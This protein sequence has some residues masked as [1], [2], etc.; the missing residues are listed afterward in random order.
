VVSTSN[1]DFIN[2]VN[3]VKVYYV[4]IPNLYWMK[5]AKEQS[6]WKKPLW[7]LLDVYN[8]FLDR[9]LVLIFKEEHPNL[10]HTNNLA[11]FSVKVWKIAKEFKLPVVHTIRDYYLLCP[12]S[13]MFKNEKNCEKQCLS[14]KFYSFPKKLLSDRYVDGVVGVS[15]F[16][17]NKHLS[18]GYFQNSKIKTYIYNPVRLANPS[19]S[20]KNKRKEK[21]EVILGFIGVISPTKGIEFVL[22]RLKEL[23]LP[24]VKLLIYGRG[25]NK[26]YEKKLKVKYSFQD[27]VFKGFKEPKEIYKEIDITVIPSLWHEPFSRVLIESYSYGVPVLASNRGGIP[28]NVIEGKTGFTFDPDKKG[29]F[30]EK[31]IK[32]VKLYSSGS[33]DINFLKN[34]AKDKFSVERVSME[35]I[36]IYRELLINKV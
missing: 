18:S 13:T 3:G 25:I 14:C 35:Y 29:D 22:E 1:R 34:F 23:N 27:I 17:L 31:L 30:E 28:E 21:D 15:E 8:L 4:R 32:L 24:N 10:V 7:H 16:I 9:K 20:P 5:T 6:K 36:S 12:S 26:E 2:W 19:D 11:G 33:F